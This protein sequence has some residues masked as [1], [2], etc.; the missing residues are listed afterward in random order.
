ML[1][2]QDNASKIL[3]LFFIYIYLFLL[4]AFEAGWMKIIYFEGGIWNN[5][6]A[7]KYSN[8]MDNV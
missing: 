6:V 8:W 5:S 2:A 4:I 3:K 7:I 1:T